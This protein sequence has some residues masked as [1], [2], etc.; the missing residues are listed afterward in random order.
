L[1]ETEEDR[2]DEVYVWLKQIGFQRYTRMLKAKGFDSLDFIRETGIE[3]EDLNF[4][5]I[6]EPLARKSIRSAA[7]KLR[8]DDDDD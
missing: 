7:R 6:K 2:V 3:M 8:G 4:V 1:P 5:G